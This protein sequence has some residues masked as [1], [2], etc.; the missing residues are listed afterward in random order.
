MAA[1]TGTDADE[2][3]NTVFVSPTVT[4]SGGALP[5]DADDTINAGGGV[6]SVDAGGGSDTVT[7][8]TGNDTALLGDGDDLFESGTPATAATLSRARSG[9]TRSASTAPAP[10]K[11]STSRP[12]AAARG[13]SATWRASQWTSTGPRPS[14]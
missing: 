5:S 2:T 1:F 4:T 12:T 13:S 14:T 9:P 3:I 8:G 6:D 11:A 10:T 7:G